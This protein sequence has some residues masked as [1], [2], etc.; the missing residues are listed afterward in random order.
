MFWALVVLSE[1]LFWILLGGFALARYLWGR[2]RL[3]LLFLVALV[4]NEYWL[5]PV[6]VRDVAH[7]GRFTVFHADVLLEAVALPVVLLVWGKDLF[8]RIDRGAE[9]YVSEVR[10]IAESEGLGLPKSAVA[11]LARS[12]RGRAAQHWEETGEPRGDGSPPDLDH[13]RRQRRRW[14]IHL[15]IFIVG[16]GLIQLALFTGFLEPSDGLFFG[17]GPRS[18]IS[19]GPIEFLPDVTGLRTL[20]LVV[21]VVDFVWSFSYTLWPK[22]QAG[23]TA[24]D[25]GG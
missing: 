1:A 18:A 23:E 6:A 10:A 7:N 21:L 8:R 4:V 13:A 9:R 17:N 20:W 25:R 12:R 24:R 16:Q 14:Y 2:R 15:A 3:S 11:A 19:L 22:E 5:V